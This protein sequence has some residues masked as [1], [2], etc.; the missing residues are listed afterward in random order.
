MNLIML[1]A[2]GA[3]KV[4]TFNWGKELVGHGNVAELRRQAG[5]DPE[6]IA[7]RILERIRENSLSR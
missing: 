6:S 4:M 1:G 7:R 2:P 3:G 5:M